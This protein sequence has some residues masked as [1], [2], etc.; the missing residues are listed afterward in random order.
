MIMYKS[1]MIMSKVCFQCSCEDEV[2]YS[3]QGEVLVFS[4]LFF[5]FFLVFLGLHPQH[6][7]VPRVGVK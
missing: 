2:A 1:H 3:G 4:F 5:F 6:M 7:D